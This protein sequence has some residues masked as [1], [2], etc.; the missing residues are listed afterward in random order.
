MEVERTRVGERGRGTERFETVPSVLMQ[1][2]YTVRQSQRER[3][4]IDQESYSIYIY[5]DKRGMHRERRVKQREI[6]HRFYSRTKRHAL[7]NSNDN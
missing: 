6:R 3:D 4:L 2:G 5:I 7:S 1:D